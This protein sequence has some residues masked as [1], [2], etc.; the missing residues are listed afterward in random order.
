MSLAIYRWNEKL[1]P[2]MNSNLLQGRRLMF[3]ESAFS[4]DQ[5]CQYSRSAANED[6][7]PFAQARQRNRDASHFAVTHGASLSLP[8]SEHEVIDNQRAIGQGEEF[9]EADGAHRRIA[10]VEVTRTPLQIDSPE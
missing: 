7:P 1:P 9:A 4:R 2:A 8:F 5:D 10:S 6:L 3:F